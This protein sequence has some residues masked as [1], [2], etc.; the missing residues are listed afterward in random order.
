MDVDRKTNKNLYCK[1]KNYDLLAMPFV[2]NAVQDIRLGIKNKLVNF[3]LFH[4]NQD[5]SGYLVVNVNEI[6]GKGQ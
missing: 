4:T 2:F 3:E 5:L 1:H 6:S